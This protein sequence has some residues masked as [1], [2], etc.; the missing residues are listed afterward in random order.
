MRVEAIT[1]DSGRVSLAGTL[2]LPDGADIQCD[3]EDAAR[4]AG[5]NP[6]VDAMILPGIIHLLWRVDGP[7]GFDTYP[8]QIAQPVDPAVTD[9]MVR[10]LQRPGIAGQGAG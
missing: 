8:A 2:A 10:W 3:P 1:T 7:S 4:I 6:S 5:L 9:A